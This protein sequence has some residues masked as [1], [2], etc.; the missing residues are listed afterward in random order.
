MFELQPNV[1]TVSRFRLTEVILNT[2]LKLQNDRRHSFLLGS[3]RAAPR[4]EGVE[5]EKERE[6]KEEESSRVDVSRIQT[7]ASEEIPLTALNGFFG[8]PLFDMNVV[9]LIFAYSVDEAVTQAKVSYEGY[10]MYQG[11]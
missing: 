7:I 6:G 1:K 5:I 2:L 9:K 8:H 4:T 3:V 10:Q 11:Y